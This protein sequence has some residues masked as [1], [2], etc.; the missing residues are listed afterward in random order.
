MRRVLLISVA[1]VSCRASL[2]TFDEC[3]SD[4][5]CGERSAD[6]QC[7]D[8][9]CVA[10]PPLDSRC[11][12]LGDSSANAFVF[13]SVLPL[14]RMDG[15]PNATGVARMQSLLLA[16]E[17]TNPPTRQGVRGKP[18][19]LISC[20]STSRTDAVVELAQ[21]LVDRRVRAV[22]SST[23]A[24]TIAASR[25]TV[26]A[27]AVLMSVSA[28][29]AELSD[30]ADRAPDAGL[31]DPGLVWR[32]AAPDTLQA[33]VLAQFLTD[34]GVQRTAV[35]H[36]N[37]A[38]GQG[39]AG[40]FAREF[41]GDKTMFPFTQDGPVD[42]ALDGAA[43]TNPGA[44]LIIA[45]PDDA[46][47]LARGARSRPALQ[48][49]QLVFTDSARSPVLI[50]PETIGAYGTSGATAGG[51]ALQYFTGQ[52]LTRFGSDPLAFGATANAFDAMMCLLL[53]LHVS[54]GEAGLSLAKGLTQLSQGAK[55]ALVPTSF[56]TLLR[57]LDTSGSVNVQGASGPLNF[58]ATKG[59]ASAPIE[60]W[61]IGSSGFE[62]VSVIVP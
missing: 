23:S 53:A 33:G 62:G 57:E 12:R 52:Y 5:E 41:R 1:V 17:Q 44:L 9:L 60:L 28:T 48:A 11:A 47:R 50:V 40:A 36:V 37:D 27:G 61:R 29:A 45:F 15:T 20:D 24:E 34:A 8:R 55:V 54:N 38:Y 14:T 31:Q 30:L 43:S 25:V 2:G 13:G 46:V 22:I 39:L 3:T 7:V 18:I 59:E 58:D 32:T 26:P 19:A 10:R 4:A 21:H 16:I 6:L 49:A 42:G 51:E 56:T 35:V